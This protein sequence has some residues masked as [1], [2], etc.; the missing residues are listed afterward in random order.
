MRVDETAA[1]FGCVV[2]DIQ[3]HWS[4]ISPEGRAPSGFIFLW[5]VDDGWMHADPDKLMIDSRDHPHPE[6]WMRDR[7]HIKR[8]RDLAFI[9]DHC[10]GLFHVAW[11][12]ARHPDSIESGVKRGVRDRAPDRDL[13]MKLTY[14]PDNVGHFAAESVD[15][16]RGSLPSTPSDL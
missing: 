2:T 13:I 10:N 4:G 16:W 12:W 6:R 14:G 7:G 9:R 8:K 15:G 3:S 5:A 11:N 1:H